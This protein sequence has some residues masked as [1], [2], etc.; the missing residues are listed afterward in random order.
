MVSQNVEL[1][2]FP[3]DSQLCDSCEKRADILNKSDSNSNIN[4]QYNKYDFNIN[5]YYFIK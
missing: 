4:N 2:L 5:E 1:Q 3:Y